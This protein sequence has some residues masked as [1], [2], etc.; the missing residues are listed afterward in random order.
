MYLSRI[1]ME[2][3]SR[4]VRSALR[5]AQQMHRMLSGLFGTGREE[6]QL[7]YRCVPRGARLTVYL[8]SAVPVEEARLLPP[9]TLAAQREMSAWLGELEEGGVR[10]FDLLTMPFRKQPDASGG[11][12][13]RRVL[14]SREERLAWLERKAEQNGFRILRAEETAGEKSSAA[15]AA[16]RGGVLY[17]DSYRYSGVLQI[18]DAEAFRNAVRRG[19]GAGK[20]YG[21][22]MLLLRG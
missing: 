10:S 17:L 12:S 19:I 14:R 7:L 13:R 18:T 5:D 22:G 2:I 11:N 9:M 6:A 16:G 3:S 4:A 15:H 8:Y 21:L 1:D 20:A